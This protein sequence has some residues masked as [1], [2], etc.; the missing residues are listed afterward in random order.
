MEKIKE[1]LKTRWANQLG[2]KDDKVFEGVAISVKPFIVSDEQLTQFVEG[3]KD[4]LTNYQSAADKVRT[5][6]N[7]KIKALEGEKADLEAK[8]NGNNNPE[9]NPQ[10][11]P[12]PQ[13]AV[14][15][16][17]QLLIESNKTL[18][19]ELAGLKVAKAK[20]DAVTALD[21]FINEWDY[22]GGFP[23]ERDLAKHIAMKVYKAGG[24][25]MNGEELIAAFREEFD[26]AVKD[27]GV[28]DF[29]KPFNSDGGGGDS[30]QARFE[31]MAKRQQ[32]RQGA[33]AGE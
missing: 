16:W 20:E 32:E 11:P 24:E 21:K 12:K 14:P 8:F 6:L 3:A 13:D 30:H 5:E 29:S 33:V 27:K 31:A 26:P 1:A 19:E 10:D 7:A 4:M 18:K 22:A 15:E 9:P 23:K 28:T 17:A 25:Q 2:I